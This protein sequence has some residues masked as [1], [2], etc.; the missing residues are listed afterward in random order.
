[1][2][3]SHSKWKYKDTMVTRRALRL[4]C[5]GSQVLTMWI[6]KDLRKF[7]RVSS[8]KY[9]PYSLILEGPLGPQIKFHKGRTGISELQDTKHP[10]RHAHDCLIFTMEISITGKGVFILN[11]LNWSI[12]FY[13]LHRLKSNCI[14]WGRIL[15]T[16][17]PVYGEI[18]QMKFYVS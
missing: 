3:G 15:S 1:M 7:F 9:I 12:P 5:W 18:L 2:S 13:W 16:C 8:L 6:F 4:F 10:K 17:N 14:I 11:C